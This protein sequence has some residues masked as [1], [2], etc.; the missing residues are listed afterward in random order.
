MKEKNR[1]LFEHYD[2]N[3]S[4]AYYQDW[5][6]NMGL[7]DLQK[8][9]EAYAEET[10]I[11]YPGNLGGCANCQLRF[12]KTVARWW[13][14]QKEKLL[15]RDEEMKKLEE[16][17]KAEEEKKKQEKKTEEKKEVKEEKKDA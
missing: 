13:F 17:K 3:L 7:I 6:R 12:L 4:T 9:R 2:G 14:P 10:G 5:S 16:K 15:K 8:L 11:N 1:V